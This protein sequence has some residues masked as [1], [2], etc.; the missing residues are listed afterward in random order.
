GVAE[1]EDDATG[2]EAGLLPELLERR[3]DRGDVADLAAGDRARRELDGTAPQHPLALRP[4]VLDLGATDEVVPDVD[5]DDAMCHHCSFTPIL[6]GRRTTARRRG[7]RGCRP[8]PRRASTAR[9]G[10]RS[11]DPPAPTRA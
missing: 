4:G 11:C 7:R 6:G 9:T 1:P 8:M 3:G 5:P 2:L 10:S